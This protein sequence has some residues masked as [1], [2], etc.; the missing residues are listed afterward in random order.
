MQALEEQGVSTGVV[1]MPCWELFDAQDQDYRDAVLI[2]GT[3]RVAVEAA[4]KMGWE[5]YL[6]DAGIFVGMSDYGLSG[7]ADALYRHFGITPEAVVSAALK[8]CHNNPC[9]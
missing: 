1:S 5:R 3:A 6:G 4:V 7:A 8:S 2:P 9:P